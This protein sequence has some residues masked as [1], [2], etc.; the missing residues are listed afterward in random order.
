MLDLVEVA[1]RLLA[2]AGVSRA[3]AAG[4]CTSCDR[5]RFFSH[6]RDGAASGRQAGL[7]WVEEGG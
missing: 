6:R 7:A 5:D 3:E 2:E 4:V 1:R